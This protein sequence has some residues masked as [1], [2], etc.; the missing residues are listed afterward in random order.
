METKEEFENKVRRFIL[1]YA[2]KNLNVKEYLHGY[3]MFEN[4]NDF[5]NNIRLK[6]ALAKILIETQI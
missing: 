4:F 6:S 2:I 3:Q 1:L 5:S